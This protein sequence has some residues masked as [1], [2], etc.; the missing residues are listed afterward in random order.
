MTLYSRTRI[1]F[2]SLVMALIL[3]GCSEGSQPSV[4][5]QGKLAVHL[6]IGEEVG[7]VLQAL[8][9]DPMPAGTGGTSIG[10]LRFAGR[11]IWIFFNDV[12]QARQFRFDAPFA[13]DI[14][15]A[16]IGA[17][18]EQ[19][20]RVLGDPGAP[21]IGSPGAK[22][23]VYHPDSAL[24]IRC[25]FDQAEK[26]TTIRVLT[27]EVTFTVPVG[28]DGKLPLA[29]REMPL[30]LPDTSIPRRG[31]PGG[32]RSIMPHPSGPDR[33]KAQAVDRLMLAITNPPSTDIRGLRYA[34]TADSATI[35]SEL[36]LQL[37]PGNPR[38]NVKHPK[39]KVM[40]GTIAADIEP[41]VSSLQKQFVAPL[42]L[43]LIRN[44]LSEHLDIQDIAQLTEYFKSPAGQRYL[45][46]EEK[47]DSL[48]NEGLG[49]G[50]LESSANPPNPRQPIVERRM[51]LLLNGTMA[52][53]SL[54]ANESNNDVGGF[55]GAEFYAITVTPL[56]LRESKSLD[57]LNREF[58][59]DLPAFEAF[60][61]SAA[62]RKYL[63]A[64][65]K[66]LRATEQ[67]KIAWIATLEHTLEIQFGAKWGQ[68]Y[69][70]EIGSP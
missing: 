27:G 67:G 13:G 59:A 26:V 33:E 58:G 2:L 64:I 34:N 41:Q 28:N 47:V 17:S 69:H 46:L 70:T 62:A 57:E 5:A 35:A 40:V 60:S 36:V 22:F 12:S 19:V 32:F 10:E 21:L 25:D 54:F 49:G 29:D 23:Y 37:D 24:T 61:R 20:Q 43:T 44:K 55:G 38:W 63:S 6:A 8:Y 56:I 4:Q 18:V 48:V 31:P 7:S 53:I 68:R 50:A 45:A 39:W 14:H 9:T 15:G 66:A 51:R 65:S 42:L 52:R 11:G 3:V 30:V 1:T 16:R